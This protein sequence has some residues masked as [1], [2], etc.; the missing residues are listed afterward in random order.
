MIDVINRST[1]PTTLPD[2]VRQALSNQVISHRSKQFEKLIENITKN[3]SLMVNSS[4][5]PLLL[6]G[7]G[8][9][10]L[11]AGISSIITETDTVLVLSAGYYGDLLRIIAKTYCNNI[12]IIN[13]KPGEIIDDSRLKNILTKKAYKVILMTHSESSTGVLH[14]IKD[15]INTIKKYSDALILIDAVSSLG[16]TSINFK[17]WGIDL[18]VSATQKGLMSPPG[19]AI[20]FLSRKAKDKIISNNSSNFYCDLSG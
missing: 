8:T 15:I 3:L 1:G 6:T 14:P 9:A 13:Y 16:V 18:M 10:G 11:D 19:V 4:E 12:D 7:S 17:E 2:E 5:R 20:I